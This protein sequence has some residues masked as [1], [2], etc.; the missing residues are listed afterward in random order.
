M[1]NYPQ[2]ITIQTLLYIE[3]SEKKESD[4]VLNALG[5]DQKTQQIY[6]IEL[7]RSIVSREILLCSGLCQQRSS[8]ISLRK[9][10]SPRSLHSAPNPLSPGPYFNFFSETYLYLVGYRETVW[11]ISITDWVRF[12][13]DDDF[14]NENLVKENWSE[15]SGRWELKMAAM[16]MRGGHKG[17]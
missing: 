10:S 5:F 16:R 1:F 15:I 14:F 13:A 8:T 11:I 2:L 9:V 3:V 7:P 17:S 6:T 12:H 4:S